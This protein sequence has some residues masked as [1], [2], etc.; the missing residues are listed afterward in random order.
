MPVNTP[1]QAALDGIAADLLAQV[2]RDSQGLY[3]LTPPGLP[4]ADPAW[5]LDESLFSGSTGVVLFFVALFQHS[6]QLAHRQAAE[7]GTRWLVT[8]AQGHPPQNLS[9]FS[10]RLGIVYL[11]CKLYEA[12]GAASWL[13]DAQRLARAMRVSLR[14]GN[15][16]ADLLGGEAG[17]LFVLTYLYHLTGSAEWLPVLAA[18]L[19]RLV[20]G[21]RPSRQGLKWGHQPNALDSLTGLSHGASGIAYVLFELGHYFSLPALHWLADQALRYEAQYFRRSAGGWLDLRV[22]SEYLAEERPGRLPRATLLVNKGRTT[23]WAHGTA[24]I[25]LVRLRAF[26]LRPTPRYQQEAAAAL[27]HTLRSLARHRNPT[28]CTLSSGLGGQVELL[29]LAAEAL[30][31]AQLRVRAQHVM[32]TAVR[33]QRGPWPGKGGRAPAGPAL[34][35][36]TAG[37]G[38]LLLRT[39]QAAGTDSLLLPRLPPPRNK[40]PHPAPAGPWQTTATL[41]QAVW[42]RYFERTLALLAQL[43][44]AALSDLFTEEIFAPDAR[45]LLACQAQFHGLVQALPVPTK[46][47][48]EEV[49]RLEKQALVLLL[50]QPGFIYQDAQKRRWQKRAQ[51]LATLDTAAFLQLSFRLTP[52]VRLLRNRWPWAAPASADWL[53]NL[54]APVGEY[55]LLLVADPNVV[56]E[57]ALGPFLAALLRFL[58]RPTSAASALQRLARHFQLPP[59]APAPASLTAALVVQLNYFLTAGIIELA[60]VPVNSL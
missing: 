22:Y 6:G 15:A 30:G 8:H 41:R 55:P 17:S 51:Q 26:Q 24:G 53:R 4:T 29:L 25:G 33:R 31:S 10:G 2:R 23:S 37:I 16:S 35:T 20:Q 32:L 60:D 36:G 42:G 13:R 52:R 11:C 50:R 56:A 48:V 9:F 40:A 43:T 45:E 28:D 57:H 19:A 39:L 38:Y 12:T 59:Q 44:P 49:F 54:A 47:V 7:D 21:A 18:G 34:L 27:G 58:S 14:A 5:L 3:W 1:I 46:A